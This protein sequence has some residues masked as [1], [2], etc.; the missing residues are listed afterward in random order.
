MSLNIVH[1]A[2]KNLLLRSYSEQGM[3]KFRKIVKTI[4]YSNLLKE[5]FILPYDSFSFNLQ[6][7]L[8]LIYLDDLYIP[9]VLAQK[10]NMFI[11]VCSGLSSKQKD[12]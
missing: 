8:I 1:L 3:E 5:F 7:K 9:S 12:N 11:N 10:V 6:L 4:V 2:P